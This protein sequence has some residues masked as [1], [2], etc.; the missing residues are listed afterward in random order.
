[1]QKLSLAL[2]AAIACLACSATAAGAAP[3]PSK[4][5]IESVPSGAFGYVSSPRAACADGRRVVLF[6]M[7]GDRRVPA[8]DVR[9][10]SDRAAKSEDSF[11]WS[12]ETG[13][14]GRFYAQAPASKG[15]AAA[16][17]RVLRAAPAVGGGD[18]PGSNY[19]P[20]SPY[21]SEGTSQ[22]C[23][24]SE[25]YLD[26]DQEGPFNPCRFGSSSGGCPGQANGLFPWGKTGA[27]GRPRA[28]ISW[29]WNGTV[30][31][32][33]VASEGS[34]G[35]LDGTIPNSGS[36]RFTV[37][38]AFARNDRGGGNGDNFFTP[39]LSGQG[40]GEVGGPLK[41]NFKNGSGTNFGAEAWISGYLFLKH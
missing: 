21:V 19:P 32:L 31:I 3:A 6:S 16:L 13:R 37:T 38:N 23:E 22:I 39:N 41:L 33:E 14:A 18:S 15:C 2:V 11:L 9:V 36:D 40:P 34:A 27:R 7:R 29:H 26:L 17:S 4:L 20:C 28:Q 35:R 25:L 12:V 8:S 30:R 1:M 5:T 24:F 10:G